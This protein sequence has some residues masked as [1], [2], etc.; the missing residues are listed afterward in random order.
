[1]QDHRANL[2]G[3]LKRSYFGHGLPVVA[4]AEDRG[5]SYLR[6]LRAASIAVISLCALFLS[7]TQ[8][9]GLFAQE[10]HD[11]IG[12]RTGLPMK[13]SFTDMRIS[14]GT[15]TKELKGCGDH[16]L[17]VTIA[18]NRLIIHLY[19]QKDQYTTYARSDADSLIAVGSKNNC[20]VEMMFGVA[21]KMLAYYPL[22]S[23]SS[24][25]LPRIPLKSGESVEVGL[26]EKD[27]PR[28]GESKLYILHKRG[29]LHYQFIH[30]DLKLGFLER[31]NQDGSWSVIVGRNECA[32]EISG[33]ARR[34]HQH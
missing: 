31:E 7:T 20:P 34:A 2:V 16:E 26:P 23:S 10:L 15:F 30:I 12:P 5:V 6:S 17:I 18:Q 1:M 9:V 22:T 3:G 11:E 25:L 13:G 29:K 14:F 28:C 4:E 8:P 32:M 27:R 19:S 21:A 33:F 24:A